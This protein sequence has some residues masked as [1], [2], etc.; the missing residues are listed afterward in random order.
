MPPNATHGSPSV[1]TDPAIHNCVRTPIWIQDRIID[2]LEMDELAHVFY[3][4]AQ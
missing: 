4:K 2:E 3:N 1:P